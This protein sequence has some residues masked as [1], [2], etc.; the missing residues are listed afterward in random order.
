MPTSEN[1][2]TTEP[3][4]QL[5]AGPL[6]VPVRPGCTSCSVRVF[7]T[8][9]GVRTAVGFTSEARL[10]NTLGGGQPWIRLSEAALRALVG[11]LGIAAL[12][13][14][15]PFSAPAAQSYP[16]P[17]PYPESGGREAVRPDRGERPAATPRAASPSTGSAL[18]PLIG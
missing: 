11:P 5:P 4:E 6:F 9:P 7:R 17:Y 13:V 16:Y 12:T 1:A 8:P 15:P 10:R 3:P 2:D 18:R 14:D